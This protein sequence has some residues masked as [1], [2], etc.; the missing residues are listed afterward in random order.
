MSSIAF[1]G[2]GVN[3]TDYPQ[4]DNRQTVF[5][6]VHK[7]TPANSET[8]TITHGTDKDNKRRISIIKASGEEEYY[9]GFTANV[10]TSVTRTDTETTTI[11][12]GSAANAEGEFTV[13]IEY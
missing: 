7:F 8:V 9:P 11:V 3:N 10:L 12:F 4:D 6:S 5:R 2:A 1:S 13:V